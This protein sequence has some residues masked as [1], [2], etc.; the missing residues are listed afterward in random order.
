MEHRQTLIEYMQNPKR[1]AEAIA[2]VPRRKPG[3]EDYEP[4]TGISHVGLYREMLSNANVKS[5]FAEHLPNFPPV[6]FETMLH[7]FGIKEN[8]VH[9]FFDNEN[10]RFL[11]MQQPLLPL[12]PFNTIENASGTF[13]WERNETLRRD[14]FTI[15]GVNE[16]RMYAARYIHRD[17]TSSYELDQLEFSGKKGDPQFDQLYN[18]PYKHT[19]A[20][21]L[22]TH[23][24]SEICKVSEV[25]P[26]TPQILDRVFREHNKHPAI[27]QYLSKVPRKIALYKQL[28]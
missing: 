2:N 28:K 12:R 16:K 19:Q 9:V 1:F 8:D 5:Y 27:A 15:A 26:L 20:A 13:G 21:G 10:P 24:M 22:L 17:D 25:H 3:A 7:F 14:E 4:R 23:R 18:V 11:A 6:V